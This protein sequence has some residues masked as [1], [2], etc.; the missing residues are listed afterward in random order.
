[1]KVKKK[2]VYYCDFCG[3]YYL[4]IDAMKN[5]EE[6]CTLNQNRVCKLDHMDVDIPD[7][8]NK[9]K[10]LYEGDGFKIDD[11]REEAEYC[12]NCI[13]TVIRC[14]GI[15]TYS[16]KVKGEWSYKQEMKDWWEFHKR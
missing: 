8:V 16:E 12:P 15:T 2:N 6:G 1:M 10:K 13:L 5:H 3:K 4:R 14:A 7:L 11:L 9:Y